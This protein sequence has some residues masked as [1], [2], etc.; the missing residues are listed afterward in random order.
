M[1][2]KGDLDM[3]REEAINELECIKHCEVDTVKE[4]KA[5]DLALSALRPVS[6]EKVENVWRG[7]EYCGE[8]W[9]TCNP[10][11][12]RF[13]MPPRGGIRLCPMCGKPLT[14][15]AVQMVMERMKELK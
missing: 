11:T 5:L 8:E 6:R 14:D 13:T 3:T 1:E 7:C 9:G 4:I 2:P 12:N 10:I 15:E